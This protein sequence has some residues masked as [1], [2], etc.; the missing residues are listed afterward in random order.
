MTLSIN[1]AFDGGNIEVLSADDARDIRLNIRKDNASDFYQWFYFRL[2][3]AK[4]ESCRMVMENAK[5]AA[6]VGGW[7]GYRACA[8]ER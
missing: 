7:D 6:F 1:S 2:I 4:G 5:D 3:G 8:R